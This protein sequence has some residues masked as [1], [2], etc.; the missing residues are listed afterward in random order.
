[1]R[2][3]LPYDLSNSLVCFIFGRNFRII[4]RYR[5]HGDSVLRYQAPGEARCRMGGLAGRCAVGMLQGRAFGAARAL[6]QL[7]RT[8]ACSG[9]TITPLYNF[10]A[11]ST[12][13]KVATSPVF[14]L[15]RGKDAKC[16]EISRLRSSTMTNHS[17]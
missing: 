15:N 7:Y 12:R 10:R 4:P 2:M 13:V 16:Q 5:G 8:L 3:I 6:S 9:R 1:V 11:S 14:Q 17:E